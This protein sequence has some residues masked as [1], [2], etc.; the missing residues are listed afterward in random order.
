MTLYGLNDVVSAIKVEVKPKEGEVVLF[1]DA[2]YQGTMYSVN[3]STPLANVKDLNKVG[4]N[5]K[6][7]S[8]KLGPHTKVTLFSPFF[9]IFHFLNVFSSTSSYISF[10]LFFLKVILY[11]HGNYGGTSL[12][13]HT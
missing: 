11:E 6:V 1:E 8:F 10:F 3:A 4:L 9:N 13:I 2:N 5:D 7:S 12:G